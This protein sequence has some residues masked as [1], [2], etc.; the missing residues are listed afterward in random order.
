MNPRSIGRKIIELLETIALTFFSLLLFF[1]P[2][3]I[4]LCICTR[5]M[6]SIGI[7]FSPIGE[8]F[9]ATVVIIP[10]IFSAFIYAVLISPF[11]MWLKIKNHPA[12]RKIIVGLNLS[13]VPIYILCMNYYCAY[14]S[15]QCYI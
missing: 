4:C 10:V 15:N 2:I 12:E 7:A 13:F 3:Y 9:Y 11:I 1:Y 5:L 14:G 8:T 6:Q